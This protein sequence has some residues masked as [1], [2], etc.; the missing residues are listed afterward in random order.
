MVKY[1]FLSVF[2][3]ITKLTLGQGEWQFMTSNEDGVKNSVAVVWAL[4]YPNDA[5]VGII[6][7]DGGRFV[8]SVFNIANNFDSRYK[9]RVS[10][11]ISNNGKLEFYYFSMEKF[12]DA[13]KVDLSPLSSNSDFISSLK[14]GQNFFVSVNNQTYS[15][16]LRKSGAILGKLGI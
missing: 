6:K 4:E 13:L 16:T 9:H 14:N 7:G 2:V 12:Q 10:F 15:F 5:A 11:G 1:L 3:S 8:L